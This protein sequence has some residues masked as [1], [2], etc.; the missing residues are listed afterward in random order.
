MSLLSVV[1]FKRGSTVLTCTYC[2]Y[3]AQV[4]RGRGGQHS[5]PKQAV[6][7]DGERDNERDEGRASL[8]GGKQ[9]QERRGGVCIFGVNGSMLYV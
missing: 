9:D 7:G 5:P 8:R 6:R 2:F 3:T 4:Q 1:S